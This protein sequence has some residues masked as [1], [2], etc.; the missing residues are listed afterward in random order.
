[1]EGLFQERFL[2]TGFD[3]TILK[4]ND[5]QFPAFAVGVNSVAKV[6][7]L[8][9]PEFGAKSNEGQASHFRWAVSYSLGKRADV[10]EFIEHGGD[11][12]GLYRIQF[13]LIHG[14]GRE[15]IEHGWSVCGVMKGE[16]V[17]WSQSW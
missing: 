13:F 11:D 9:D 17:L 1:M 16:D 4:A 5:E 14:K 10:T 7:E 3:L 8:R 2:D 6:F 12:F 15:D